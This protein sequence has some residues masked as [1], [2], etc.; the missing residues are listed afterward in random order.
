MATV[1]H[2]FP[3]ND[4]RTLK[5]RAVAHWRLCA[6]PTESDKAF[7]ETVL[8]AAGNAEFP[9]V[10]HEV[11]KHIRII[12]RLDFSQ[13]IHIDAT[14]DENANILRAILARKANRADPP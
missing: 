14:C 4:L 6:R 8:S 10:Y 2:L 1:S 3:I 13:Q 7:H 9:R 5:L 12:R 11:T